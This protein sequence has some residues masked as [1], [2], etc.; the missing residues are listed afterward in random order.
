[1]SRERRRGFTL[2]ESIMVLL[3]M[4]VLAVLAT[5]LFLSTA[6]N[7]QLAAYQADFTLDS[8]RALSMLRSDL[9][10][11]AFSNIAGQPTPFTLST[12][13][14]GAGSGITIGWQPLGP[15]TRGTQIHFYPIT[16]FNTTTNKY[17]FGPQVTYTFLLSN[18]PP[19]AAAP[20]YGTFVGPFATPS[21]IV[22][23]AIAK[24]YPAGNGSANPGVACELVRSVNGRGAVVAKMIRYWPG[25]PAPGPIPGNP[26]LPPPAPPNTP[27]PYYATPMPIAPYFELD[28]RNTTTPQLN[29]NFE[30]MQAVKEEGGTTWAVYTRPVLASFRLQP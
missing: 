23:K 12:P 11:A 3:I 8:E 28:T 10:N 5:Q 19:P 7:Q 16:G 14:S 15:N 4:S 22:Q 2:L 18:N 27:V 29:V 13:G 24:T 21:L 9:R 26:V 30:L 1:M 25:A 6:Q 17:T 20:F